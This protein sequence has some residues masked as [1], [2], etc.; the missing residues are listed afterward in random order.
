[1]EMKRA[2]SLSAVLLVGALLLLRPD[3][4]SGAVLSGIQVCLQS[5]VPSLFPFLVAAGLLQALGL[6]QI[7][8][9]ALSPVMGPLF[10]LRGEA[11]LPLLTGLVGGYPTG[12]KTAAALWREGVLSQQEAELLLGF[13]NNCGG[14]FLL[15]YAA[16]ALGS[17]KAGAWLWGVHVAAALLTG[18]IL[19]RVYKDRGPALLPCRLP[20]EPVT[21]PRALTSAVTG[22]ARATANICAFVVTFRVLTGLLPVPAWALGVLEMVSG[23]ET[24]SPGRAGFVAAAAIVGWGGLSVHCQTMSV[25][26]GLSLRWHWVGKAMQAGLSALL[27]LA[28]AGLV[29]R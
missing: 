23:I 26:E 2:V 27:A 1:M 19:T 29:Y 25:T 9:K 13:C 10:H 24:L 8:G 7:L 20:V 15:G 17:Q 3:D 4:A 16:A 21:L 5:V 6:A 22:A 28:V 18:M 11:A 14:A 12:A